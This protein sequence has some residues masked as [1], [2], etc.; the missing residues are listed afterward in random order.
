M[1][2]GITGGIG[3]GK[4]L[5]SRILDSMGYPI[6][7]SD[8]AAKEII[9]TNKE[10]QCA[11]TGLFGVQA[12]VNG[13]YNRPFIAKEVFGNAQKLAQLNE[14]I[15]PHVRSAF[16]EFYTRNKHTLVF[17][18]AAILFETGLYKRFD[19]S[20]LVVCPL[21]LK[22]E[23]LKS[24]DNSTKKEILDRMK[25]QWS[26]EQ[27]MKLADHIIINDEHQSVLLQLNEILKKLAKA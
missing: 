9:K 26:D 14:L 3:S 13:E 15:H 1:R 6:F 21:E 16:E 18:E 5:I 12:F 24:R 25:K 8:S 7:N 11:I 17:N 4:S 23:R 19:A 27:K 2:I 22:M 10:V 20:L